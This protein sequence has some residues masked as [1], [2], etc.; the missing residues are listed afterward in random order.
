MTNFIV[1][2]LVNPPP[3]PPPPPPPQK[4]KYQKYEMH[5]KI[6]VWG[7]GTPEHKKWYKHKEYGMYETLG[8]LNGKG[9]IQYEGI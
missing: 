5:R 6:G 7:M 8:K 2:T 1:L 4:K 3:P 9:L